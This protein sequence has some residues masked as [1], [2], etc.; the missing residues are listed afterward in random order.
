MYKRIVTTV[1][2]V[3]PL[4]EITELIKKK[5]FFN[6]REEDP[7]GRLPDPLFEVTFLL[8]SELVWVLSV[9]PL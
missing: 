9:D 5:R 1:S 8:R 4:D 7:A 3:L 6:S 2:D